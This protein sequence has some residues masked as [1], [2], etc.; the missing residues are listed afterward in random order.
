MARAVIMGGAPIDTY[1]FYTKC[2]DDFVICADSGYR[3]AVQLGI[4][5]DLVVGDFDSLLGEV[6]Q[7]I[8]RMV[9]PAEKDATD[10]QIALEYA[11]AQGYTDIYA[12]GVFGG[13]VDHFLGNISLLKMARE[14]EIN[15]LMEDADCRMTISWGTL[16]VPKTHFTYLSV[17]PLFEDATVSLAGVKYPLQ[18]KRLFR[19][20][21]LGISNEIT[22]KEAIIQIE[23]GS[24]VILCCNDTH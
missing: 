19:G 6:P 17:V 22:A 10:F 11:I 16:H 8:N 5:P 7:D 9:Y 21:T 18:K 1:D 4:K 15:F 24:A 12:I 3:H 20:D 13:R 23:N 14:K 2:V